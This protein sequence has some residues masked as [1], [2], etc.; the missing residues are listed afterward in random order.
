MDILY[1]YLNKTTIIRSF[2]N[3]QY[4][5]TIRWLYYNEKKHI[6]LRAN[7]NAYF[8]EQCISNNIPVIN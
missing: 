3:S 1:H 5:Q 8:K 4:N 7:N 2:Y 6:H